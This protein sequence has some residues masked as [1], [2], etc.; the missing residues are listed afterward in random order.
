MSNDDRSAMQDGQDPELKV[1]D[2]NAQTPDSG[3]AA[4]I[5]GGGTSTPPISDIQI[6]KHTDSTS[7]KLF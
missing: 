1:E 3:E 5:K 4:Q 7:S 2:L 6:T